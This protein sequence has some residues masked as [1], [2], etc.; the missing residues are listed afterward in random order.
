MNYPSEKIKIKDGYIWIDNN[1]IPLLSGEFHFWRNTKKFWPRILN[2][3]K[4]LGFKHITTYVEWNFHRI[5]PDGTPVGQIEYDFTGKTD[6]Q[7]NLK[8][9]LNLLDERKD[10]WLS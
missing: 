6:Q 10:F 7:T 2:S 9:Y 8:G 3:I 5:T 1:K 4:D